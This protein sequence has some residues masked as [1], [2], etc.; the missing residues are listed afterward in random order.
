MSVKARSLKKKKIGS[1]PFCKKKFQKIES[2]STG[3]GSR[4]FE[5]QIHKSDY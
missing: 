4:S 5:R 3:P 2:Q 1:D